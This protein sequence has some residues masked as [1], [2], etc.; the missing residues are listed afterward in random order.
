MKLKT[1]EKTLKEKKMSKGKMISFNGG[2]TRTGCDRV[3][4][5]V[6]EE[7]TCS[8]SDSSVSPIETLPMV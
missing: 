2:Y 8:D 5:T 4:V 1:L 6:E 3:F 7:Y